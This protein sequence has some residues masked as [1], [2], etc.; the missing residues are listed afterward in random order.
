MGQ[1]YGGFATDCCICVQSK[2]HNY[3]WRLTNL[4]VNIQ[5]CTLVHAYIL[6][7]HAYIWMDAY[8]CVWRRPQLTSLLKATTVSIIVLVFTHYTHTLNSNLHTISINGSF[9]YYSFGSFTKF[10][11]N[12]HKFSDGSVKKWLPMVGMFI[13]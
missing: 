13:A 5:V 10:F 8:T 3:I 12:F 2:L 11:M 1:V 4:H 9:I 7:V 6:Y